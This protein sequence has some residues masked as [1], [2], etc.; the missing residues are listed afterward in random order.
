VIL[1]KGATEDLSLVTLL[2][3]AG[4]E[5]HVVGDCRG[6]G[7]IAQAMTD[8]ADIAAAMI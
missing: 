5:V 2:R 8:A 1:A 3:E 6:V 4:I 7:Y